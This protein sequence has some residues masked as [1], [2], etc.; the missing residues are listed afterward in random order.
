[1]AQ[2]YKGNQQRERSPLNRQQVQHKPV[3]HKNMGTAPMAKNGSRPYDARQDNRNEKR[4]QKNYRKAVMRIYFAGVFSA[5]IAG[6][7]IWALI[8]VMHNDSAAIADTEPAKEA[9][10]PVVTAEFIPAPTEQPTVS[11]AEL[12]PAA[13]GFLILVNWDN[14]VPYERPDDLVVLDEMFGNEV[15]LVNGEGSINKTA[16]YAAREMF[17][18]AMEDGIGRYKLSSAYRSIIYQ[19]KLWK[20]RKQED[21][22]YGADPY[23]EPVKVMPGKMS[24]H[25]TGLALDIL[26]EAYETANDEYGETAEGKWL[27]ENAH[28]YGFIMRYPKGK[29]HITGVIY[30][31]WHYRYVGV[32]AA[33]EIYERGLCLEEYLGKLP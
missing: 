11:P 10:K 14:P 28:K 4:T 23:S 30:E 16:G 19:D 33:T 13:E 18:D 12:Y 6:G 1:M 17:Q 5:I 24:E 9:F 31:P 29:E 15:C 26:A 7:I 21:P 20:K 32:E 3:P 25:T 8:G 2:N 22:S 27:A